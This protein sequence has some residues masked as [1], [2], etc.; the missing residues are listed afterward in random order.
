M[1]ERVADV[2]VVGGG[3]IGCSIAHFLAKAGARVT[4]VERRRIAE[5]ASWASAGMI[6]PPKRAEPPSAHARLEKR[7]FDAYPALVEE[8]REFTG[9]GVEYA[10]CGEL[11]VALDGGAGAQLRGILPW[12]RELGLAAEWLDGDE[13]RRR[14]PALRADLA[15][16]AWFPEAGN[17]RAHRLTAALARSAQLRG[18]MIREASPVLGLLTEGDRVEGVRIAGGELR[19][20]AT[21]LATGAWTAQLGELAGVALPTMPLHGQ[22][23]ALAGAEPPLRHVISGGGGYL[24]PRADGTVAVGAT[25]DERGFDAAVTPAGLRWLADLV[26]RLTQGWLGARVA[27]TWAGLRPGSADGLPLLGPAPGRRGLWVAA[28]HTFYGVLWAPITGELLAGSI[29]N[30]RP[31]PALAPY[32]PGRFGRAA[33]QSSGG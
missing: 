6:A 1:S 22:M 23:L 9:L 3:V 11:V 29:V 30:G 33:A 5:E 8:L 16:A 31:D 17:L 13:A 18:A 12:Q 2:L 20:D 24:I 25:V 28:G 4:L 19:A 10:R 21:V 15:G 27:S 32:D 14:E 7:S 26:G